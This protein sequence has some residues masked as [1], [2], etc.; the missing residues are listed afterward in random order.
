M[1]VPLRKTVFHFLNA[2]LGYH[3]GTTLVASADQFIEEIGSGTKQDGVAGLS[4]AKA[5][6]WAI[7][8]LPAGGMEDVNRRQN[9]RTRRDDHRVGRGKTDPT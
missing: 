2:L 6:F 7:M 5:K 1:E 3:D 8:V 4:A 9:R